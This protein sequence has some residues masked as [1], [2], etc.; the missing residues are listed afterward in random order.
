MAT[1]IDPDYFLNRR[2]FEKFVNPDI[3]DPIG[4]F[5]Q[6]GWRYSYMMNY[7]Y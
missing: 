7:A 3:V 4:D 2:M 1:V 6:E 5:L